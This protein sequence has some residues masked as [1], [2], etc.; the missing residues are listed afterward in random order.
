MGKSQ[1]AV[2]LFGSRPDGH[3]ADDRTAEDTLQQFLQLVQ[4]K[5]G[6]D[7][8][9]LDAETTA[10]RGDQRQDRG[11]GR[12]DELLAELC[13]GAALDVARMRRGRQDTY[14]AGSQRMIAR[15]VVGELLH[16][17]AGNE[18]EK[19]VRHDPGKGGRDTA[20]A[21]SGGVSGV[22]VETVDQ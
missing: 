1:A 10:A 20:L 9:V 7:L 21:G 16:R 6:K 22:L 14:R 11:L 2:R 17:S 19:L 13:T 3:V 15:H 12:V 8:E 5:R 18:D 4:G